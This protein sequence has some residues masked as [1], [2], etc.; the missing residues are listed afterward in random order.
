MNDHRAGEEHTLTRQVDDRAGLGRNLVERQKVDWDRGITDRSA[1][2]Q[3]VQARRID[4][5]SGPSSNRARVSGDVK[6]RVIPFS[7]R[8]RRMGL[9]SSLTWVSAS[10]RTGL[11]VVAATIAR[12]SATGIPRGRSISSVSCASAT[13]PQLA[14]R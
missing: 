13:Q 5:D 2:R 4:G 8:D 12:K 7:S 3:S 1:I 9:S 14:E 6:T 11:P 10:L